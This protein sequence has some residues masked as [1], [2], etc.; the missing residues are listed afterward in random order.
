LK[1]VDGLWALK[2]GVANFFFGQ[3]IGIEEKTTFQLK[4]VF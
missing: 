3:S 2:L 4:F 1:F